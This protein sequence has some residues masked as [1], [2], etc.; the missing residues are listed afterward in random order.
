MRTDEYLR[1]PYRKNGR[2]WDGADCYGFARILLMNEK[3]ITLPF[4]DGKTQAEDKDFIPY[5]GLEAPEDLALVFLQGGPFG[6]AHVGVYIDG[7]ILHMTEKG[8][9]CQEWKRIRRYVKGIY[10]PRANLLPS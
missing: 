3:G 5:E 10:R 7:T 8:V 6:R 4:L 1:I 2:E 9:C